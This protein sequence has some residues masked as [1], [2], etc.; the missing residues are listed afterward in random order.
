[1][2]CTS[3]YSTVSIQLKILLFSFAESTHLI[4]ISA[5]LAIKILAVAVCFMCI[6][7]NFPSTYLFALTNLFSFGSEFLFKFLFS[8]AAIFFVFINFSFFRTSLV[9]ALVL[10]NKLL[11]FSVLVHKNNT[12]ADWQAVTVIKPKYHTLSLPM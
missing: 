11:I 7:G 2:N 1:M 10:V 5:V 12:G 4:K 9:L 3:R 6:I 8:S